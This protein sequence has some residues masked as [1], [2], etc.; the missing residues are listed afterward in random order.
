MACEE[1]ITTRIH[2]RAIPPI[3]LS[4]SNQ[5][6]FIERYFVVKLYE[7]LVGSGLGEGVIWFDHHQGIHPDKSATWFADRLEAIDLSIASILILSNACQHQRLMTIE[8]KA[9]ADRKLLSGTSTVYGLFVIL[10]DEC[11]DFQY[12]RSRADYFYAFNKTD[13]MSEVGER[14]SMI[15]KELLTKLIPYKQFSSIQ[16]NATMYEHKIN[17]EEPK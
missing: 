1:S 9:I 8:S 10:L 5:T 4:Y 16:N 11:H 14:V 2:H 3:Y 15:L 7:Q 12:L 6:G 17:E 13:S